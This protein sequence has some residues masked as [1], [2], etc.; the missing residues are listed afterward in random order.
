[1]TTVTYRDYYDKTLI[2][3]EGHSC[4]APKGQDLVCAGI[5]TLIYSLLNTLADEDSGDRINFIRQIIRDGYVCLEFESFDFS[6]ERVKGIVDA[7]MTGVYMLSESYP[8]NV[9]IE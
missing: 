5:S 4:S 8:Q 6:R 3:A 2:I 1:M 7:F 9:R